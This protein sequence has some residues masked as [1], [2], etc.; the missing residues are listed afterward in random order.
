MKINY[1]WFILCLIV[2]ND[3]NAQTLKEFRQVQSRK[4]NKTYQLVFDET[5]KLL[6][7]PPTFLYVE[8]SKKK[9][10]SNT[11][12]KFCKNLFKKTPPDKLQILVQVSHSYMEKMV[13]EIIEE[14][15]KGFEK[16]VKQDLS[17]YLIS[18]PEKDTIVT[19][20]INEIDDL[21]VSDYG[22]YVHNKMY[23]KNLLE[24]YKDKYGQTTDSCD[25]KNCSDS[26]YIKGYTSREYIPPIKE[27]IKPDFKFIITSFLENKQKVK[28]EYDII[29]KKGAV[30]DICE[31]CP[32]NTLLF[33]SEAIDL[34]QEASRIVFELLEQNNFLKK[35]ENWS[36]S[37]PIAIKESREKY[38]SQTGNFKEWREQWDNNN[39]DVFESPINVD[40]LFSDLI[41]IIFFVNPLHSRIVIK[42]K[43]CGKVKC[44]EVLEFNI[45][46]TYF[47]RDQEGNLIIE[48]S[49]RTIKIG[50]DEINCKTTHQASKCDIKVSAQTLL[51]TLTKHATAYNEF[52]K[53]L[54]K[55]YQKED[56]PKLKEWYKK[57]IWLHGEPRVNPFILN[58][59]PGKK[60]VI[61]NLSTH[62]HK[63]NLLN[64]QINFY[65]KLVSEEPCDNCTT[66]AA[67]SHLNKLESLITK[68][69]GLIDDIK[70]DSTDL[71]IANGFSAKQK[72]Y[73]Q[74]LFSNKSLYKGELFT[75]KE[76]S[77][78]YM[79]HHNREN[80][81]LLMNKYSKNE[82]SEE[83]R[84]FILGENMLPKISVSIKSITTPAIE[85][86]LLATETINKERGEEDEFQIVVK[87]E[88]SLIK[89]KKVSEFIKLKG[90]TY[91]IT[92]YLKINHVITY[93]EQLFQLGFPNQSVTEVKDD[94]PNFVGYQLPFKQPTR[95][96]VYEEYEI[97]ED[98]K[99]DKPDI[100]TSYRV[101]KLY[102]LRFRTGLLYSFF[103]RK[104]IKIE[105]NI[106][107]ETSTQHGVD[108]TFGL[109]Y[110][111]KRYDIR[112]RKWMPVLYGGLSMTKPLDNLYLGFGFEKLGGLS[113]IGGVH[114]SQT[115]K[116]KTINN[117]LE[118]QKNRWG[119]NLFFSILLDVE[120]FTKFIGLRTNSLFNAN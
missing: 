103:E 34:N 91:N 49:K 93:N 43:Q 83:Q 70:K 77:S 63:L 40:L 100:K 55:Y 85:E 22:K 106:V 68:R 24:Y 112:S 71:K 20:Y 25:D 10:Y 98:S 54:P 47:I 21:L 9:L 50:N 45:R 84:M 82:I 80:G 115:D 27:L 32:A 56:L 51:D 42:V 61:D 94:S 4:T 6:S 12:S 39:W 16:I 44:E 33:S 96:P 72:E 13:N 28:R 101:N 81:Y 30:E 18:K 90:S 65:Q 89:K 38:S 105:D 113:V 62:A 41:E 102:K 23:Y 76:G 46:N 15:V 69:N 78:N 119:A 8:E 88:N 86:S 120:V 7:A 53:D 107:S 31:I 117:T 104:D 19:E 35:L 116:L 2:L 92:D 11:S 75:S 73:T 60:E 114:I 3:L 5:G 109:Q 74:F 1:L 108:G 110:F 48:N 26:P 17:V 36:D 52:I 118:A 37:F 64:N 95:G 66:T 59:T 58:L 99:A 111:C 57:S 87:R 14:Y 29:E 79:R 97:K 67:Q